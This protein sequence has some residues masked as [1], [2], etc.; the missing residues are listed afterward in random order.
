M[1]IIVV[2]EL[3]TGFKGGTKEKENIKLLNEFLTNP[4]VSTI[5]ATIKTATIFSEIKHYLWKKG[6]PIPINDVWVAA[7]AYE[8]D[9]ELITFDKHF[10][11]IP[12]LKLWS[13]LE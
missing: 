1:S 5:N 6:F 3:L 12:K 7:Q 4:K 13:G 10:K 9:A 8:Y 2:A 11:N